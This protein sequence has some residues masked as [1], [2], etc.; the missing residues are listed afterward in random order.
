MRTLKAVTHAVTVPKDIL[1]RA[2]RAAWIL[3]NALMPMVA[4][5]D[6]PRV[7]TSLAVAPVVPVRKVMK[8]LARLVARI[9]MN[10]P[11]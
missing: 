9:S 7:P 5:I 11:R 4:V 10:V 8:E 1:A 2:S 3:M 6:C